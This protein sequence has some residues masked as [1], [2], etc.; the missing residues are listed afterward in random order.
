MVVEGK[1]GGWD[2]VIGLAAEIVRQRGVQR[3]A[4]VGEIVGRCM[5]THAVDRTLR[6]AHA[7]CT[8]CTVTPAQKAHAHPTHGPTVPLALR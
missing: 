8:D 3:A 6:P 7:R 2:G 4:A 1:D 5:F